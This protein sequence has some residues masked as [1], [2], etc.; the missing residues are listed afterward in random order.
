MTEAVE[1]QENFTSNITCTT[2]N[3]H[4]IQTINNCVFWIEGVAM[5]IA[6]TI[7]ILTNI[8]SIYVFTR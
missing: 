5:L 2:L 3:K 7:A 6:G 8:L 1:N 4:G